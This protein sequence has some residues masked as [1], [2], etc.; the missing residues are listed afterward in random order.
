MGVY[1]RS[2][3][4][5]FSHEAGGTASNVTTTHIFRVDLTKETDVY[6][7]MTYR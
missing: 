1:E 6:M 2:Q 5:R 3:G 7:V 4:G